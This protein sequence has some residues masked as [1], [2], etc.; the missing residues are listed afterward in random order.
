SAKIL[1]DRRWQ[2][3]V[4]D[5]SERKR[6]E[7]ERARGLEEKDVLLKEIHH[8]VKNNLQ[9]VS[10]LLYLQ[11]QRTEDREL[12]GLLDESRSRVQSIALV[13]DQ[14]C[15]SQRLAAID[16]DEYLRRLTA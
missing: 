8:R 12:Q 1:D 6:L 14:L 15:R 10:S 13:H 3:F 2:G 4:R 9:V 11:A 5:V 7:E 16:L